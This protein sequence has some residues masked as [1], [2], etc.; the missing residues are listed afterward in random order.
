[1]PNAQCFLCQKPNCTVKCNK[2]NCNTYYCSNEHYAAH[3]FEVK[4]ALKPNASSAIKSSV[5][6][7]SARNA[8]IGG[9]GESGR[10]SL[11]GDVNDI[12]SKLICLPYKILNSERIGRHFVATRDIKPL[13][14]ILVDDAAVV[15]PSTITNPVCIVCLKPTKGEFRYENMSSHFLF[16]CILHY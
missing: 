11:N 10:E 8:N 4:Y 13:E 7:K 3:T 5:N 1:M 6:D 9:D 15:G 14:L 16:H 12:A 2:P